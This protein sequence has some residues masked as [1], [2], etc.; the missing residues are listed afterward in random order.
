[1]YLTKYHYALK[2]DDDHVLML[3]SI[4]GA[5]DILDSKIYGELKNNG[6]NDSNIAE[7]VVTS[8][9]E[10]GYIFDSADEE[11][12]LIKIVAHYFEEL[13]R[14]KSKTYFVI[15]PTLEC[16]FACY[17]CYQPNSFHSNT[18]VVSDE[19]VN[20]MFS[21]MR[22]LKSAYEIGETMLVEL[23]GGEPF[24]PKTK[25]IMGGILEKARADNYKIGPIT[26]GYHI[27][28]FKNLLIDYKDVFS[29]FQITIDGPKKVHNKRRP[30]SGGGETFDTIVNSIDWLLEKGMY[31]ALRV[32]CDKNNIEY[33]NDLFDF[34]DEKGWRKSPGFYCDIAPVTAYTAKKVPEFVMPEHEI[35]KKLMSMFPIEDDKRSSFIKYR[36]FRVLSHLVGT[37]GLDGDKGAQKYP[38]FHYCEADHAQFFIFSPDGL[39]YPCPEAAGHSEF[40]IGKYW[41][42]FE[43]W[44]DKRAVWKRDVLDIPK[45]RDCNLVTF[46][47]G[48]CPYA[49][50]LNHG[51][52]KKPICNDAHKV[53]KV[54]M[55]YIRG[56]LVKRYLGQ[57][58]IR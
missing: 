46:C 7:D 20:S 44:E 47:G 40:A 10:R 50:I 55:D 13:Y 58:I 32:N 57:D 31:V 34:I 4:S 41:P 52:N 22:Q 25:N 11:T 42:V 48:G 17:Y 23:F 54:F 27:L 14:Q 12:R 1:M 43:I 8:L 37:L 6:D 56:Y 21:A 49:A 29:G 36:M 35:V 38:F 51:T 16:N 53:I 30:R 39:I 45:C 2:L 19:M 3:N 26:N 15:C 24:Q 28:D 5:V 33:L 9:K 18:G